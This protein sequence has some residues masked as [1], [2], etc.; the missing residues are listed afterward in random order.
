MDRVEF[1]A[2]EDFESD[3]KIV[4]LAQVP[5]DQHNKS[6]VNLAKEREL[7][8]WKNF[9]VYIEVED[10]GQQ[11]LSTRW[12]I[13]EKLIN[14]K[15][16]FKSRLVVRGFEEEGKVQND[17]PTAAKCSLRVF[18]PSHRITNGNVKLLM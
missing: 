18:L 15:V 13:T 2:T 11:T 1:E 16:E 9:S 17:S 5:V 4:Y 10:Q 7:Q 3:N 14:D 12:V 8:N 6:G